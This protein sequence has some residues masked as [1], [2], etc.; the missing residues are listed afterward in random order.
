MKSCKI[1][2][3][4]FALLVATLTFFSC[5]EDPI[6]TCDTITCDPGFTCENGM[7]IVDTSTDTYR[8]TGNITEDKTLDAGNC[9]ILDGRIIVEP[10]VTLTIAPGACIK[11]ETGEGALASS[12]IIAKGATINAA[13]TAANPIVFTSIGD[14]ITSG[15]QIG[16]SLDYNT[17]NGL[18][19][20]VIILGDAPI[21]PESGTTAQIEGI[22]ADITAGNYG[23]TN[24]TD[25]S[26][27]FTYVSIRFG[28]TNIGAGNEIN[29]L[30]LGGVGSG[31]TIHHVEVVANFDDGIEFFGGTVNVSDAVVVNQGDDAFDV[32]QAWSG[33]LNNFINI[34][35]N[36]SDFSLE[37][38]GPEG[39]ENAGG[40]F[41]MIN[42]TLKGGAGSM[43]IFK[44]DAQGNVGNTY[45]LNYV[46]G[47][48]VAIDDNSTYDHFDNGTLT[49]TGL[50]FDAAM[51][52]EIEDIAADDSES[53]TT[54]FVEYFAAAANNN[55]VVTNPTIGADTNAFSTWSLAAKEG[56]LTGL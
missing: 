7:C 45:F 53:G 32:D 36:E 25:N 37:I 49:M 55:T 44:K 17:Q 1:N 42:G 23:G 2:L 52:M 28:G 35:G 12:L 50:Q 13:G 19:G 20:G 6:E 9:W 38:D 18:W 11:G 5:K 48:T 30:T 8:L 43:A 22:P 56:L 15:N 34:A 26:G 4:S 33:T 39:S 54:D 31:T 46:E 27:V 29:G 47:S 10:G 16:T 21:S 40:K 14:N 3:L 51:G 24:A 41:N